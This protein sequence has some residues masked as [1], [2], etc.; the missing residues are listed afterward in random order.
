MKFIS[1]SPPISPD[2]QNKLQTK[3]QILNENI[4]YVT[5]QVDRIAISLNGLIHDLKLQRQTN[6]YFETSPQ[7][8]SDEH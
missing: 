6:E 2:L 8:E 3:L 4:L 1:S 5:H 7:T